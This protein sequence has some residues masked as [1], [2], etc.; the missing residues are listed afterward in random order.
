MQ[1]EQ[2]NLKRC[3]VGGRRGRRVDCRLQ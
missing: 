3:S 2:G 1:E